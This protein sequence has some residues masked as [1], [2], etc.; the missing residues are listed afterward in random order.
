MVIIIGFYVILVEIMV[1]SLGGVVENI[2]FVS[3]VSNGF[4]YVFNGL[5]I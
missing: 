1:L 4:N 5:I 2:G 3:I